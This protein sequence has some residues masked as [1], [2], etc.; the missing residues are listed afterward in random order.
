MKDVKLSCRS[1]ILSGT[2]TLSEETTADG[3]QLC[4]LELAFA[5]K[6]ISASGLDFFE[7]LLSLRR[8]L[9]QESTFLL[10]YGASRSVWPS[11]MTRSM[12]SGSRAYRI[13]LGKPA[14]GKDMVSIFESGPDVEPATIAEQERYRDE[15]FASLGFHL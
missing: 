12:G 2:L 14:L 7:A 9:E 13:T 6:R 15:W 3:K 4:S 11:G 8:Q 1:E 10:V 5:G